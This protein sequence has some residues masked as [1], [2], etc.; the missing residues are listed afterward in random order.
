MAAV[1]SILRRP[2]DWGERRR[3]ERERKG[4]GEG[5]G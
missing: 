4:E 3:E 2:G 1:F 5:D